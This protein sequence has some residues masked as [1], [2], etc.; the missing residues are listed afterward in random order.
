MRLCHVPTPLSDDQRLWLN[1]Q[2]NA[3]DLAS[4]MRTYKIDFELNKSIFHS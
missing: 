1:A 2:S 4:H 3:P